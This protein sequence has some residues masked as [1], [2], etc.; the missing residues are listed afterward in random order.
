MEQDEIKSKEGEMKGRASLWSS[1]AGSGGHVR[2]G[3]EE[4]L[5]KMAMKAQ[6]LKRKPEALK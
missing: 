4:V 1:R 5:K 6:V 3:Y 2:K